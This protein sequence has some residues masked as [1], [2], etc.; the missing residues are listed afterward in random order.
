VVLAAAVTAAALNA[1]GLG[2]A[3]AGRALRWPRVPGVVSA[4]VTVV[5]YQPRVRRLV[6]ARLGVTTA[7]AVLGSAAAVAHTLTL[8]P[9]SLA[10]DLVV[11]VTKAAAA[12]SAS[13]SWQR[14][15]PLLAA[16]AACPGDTATTAPRPQLVPPGPIKRHADAAG[17]AQVI[18]AT[19]I[20]ALT[21]NLA[22][23]ATAAAVAAPKA[24]RTCRES[25]A[26]TLGRGLAD[27]HGVLPM[28]PEVLR[29]LDRVDAVV[30]DP[31]AL[32][33]AELRIGAIRG[34][35]QAV[36]DCRVFAR[37]APE[38]KVAIVETLQRLGHV[39]AMVGDGANDAAAIRAATVG[40]GVASAGSD[41]A[42]RRGPDFARRQDRRAVGR[43]G[44]GTPTL[45]ARP[46]RGRG[47]LG[48]R[49]RGGGLREHRDRDH[50]PGT[51]QRPPTAAGEHAHRRATR[52]RVGRQRP[53][54]RPRRHG[55]WTGSNNLW[56]TVAVRGT[57]TTAA[58]TA[59]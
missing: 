43:P 9:A 7:D 24:A 50:R 40:I 35:E 23:A 58:A 5:D 28:A 3:V 6:E 18:V 33:V 48:R 44:G 4:V 52:R 53:P 16:H 15:E 38:H 11:Q 59:A 37:M 39:C 31:R 34:E 1:A 8:E 46:G 54:Q 26:N 29:R 57:A 17:L 55:A 27:R 47:A 45:A 22:A 12:Q 19:A 32:A 41:P 10:V 13:R 36:T 56:R 21:V 25:F 30:I 14:H 42:H 49:R 2:V 20:G 51:A